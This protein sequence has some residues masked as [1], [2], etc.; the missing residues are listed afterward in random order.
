[1]FF[2]R[3]NSGCGVANI[4]RQQEEGENATIWSGK[5]HHPQSLN[6]EITRICNKLH[7]LG[8]LLA[9]ACIFCWVI[10]K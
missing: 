9:D 4:P 6:D 10:C 3:Q 7:Q 5:V 2:L 1:M 8:H